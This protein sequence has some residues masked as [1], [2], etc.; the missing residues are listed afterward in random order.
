MASL[1]FGTPEQHLSPTASTPPVVTRAVAEPSPKA[2]RPKRRRGAPKP[3]SRG[4]GREPKLTEAKIAAIAGELAK[5]QY[6]FAVACARSGV[7]DRA[8]TYWLAM[9]RTLIERVPGKPAD[10]VTGAEPKAES[11]WPRLPATLLVRF[12]RAVMHARAAGEAAQTAKIQSAGAP[13]ASRL[14]PTNANETS[15]L[16]SRLVRHLRTRS[17]ND[18]R[19]ARRDA[20]ALWLGRRRVG[21]GQA[22]P[23][24]V[25]ETRTSQRDSVGRPSSGR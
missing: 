4:I 20:G 13:D 14:A 21:R 23:R 7:S 24:L 18:C 6:S 10:Q 22:A 12:L 16:P 17:A 5:G 19:N 9:A 3:A 15:Q 1:R 8:A 2:N 11:P 25:R